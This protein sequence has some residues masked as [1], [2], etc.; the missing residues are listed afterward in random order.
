MPGM[1]AQVLLAV[2]VTVA[3]LSMPETAIGEPQIFL[4]EPF[5][6]LDAWQPLFFPKIKAHS[7]YAS[8][9][10]GSGWVLR[11]ES[12]ASASGLV[13]KRTFDVRRFPKIRWRWKVDNIYRKA[14]VTRKS[15]DDYPIRIYVLFKYDPDRAAFGRRAS[16]AAARLLQGEYPPDSALNYVWAS[17][18]EEL[19]MHVSPYTDRVRLIVLRSGPAGVG[20]WFAEEAD[21]LADYRRAFG[22]DPPGEASLAVMS[23]SDNTGEAAVAY[24]DD[25]EVWGEVPTP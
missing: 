3:A 9:E 15:G 1:L 24:V 16:Y 8:A 22:G 18:P 23:D 11:A 19:G 21:I 14:D 13:L 6:T 10:E 2:T 5:D 4:K 25:I 17:R 12:R 7:T 20:E